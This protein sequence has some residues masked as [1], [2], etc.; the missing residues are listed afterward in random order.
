MNEIIQ[1]IS[2]KPS[3]STFQDSGFS[4]PSR[5]HSSDVLQF[6]Q[7]LQSSS[8]PSVSPIKSN[9]FSALNQLVGS[10]EE[11]YVAQ[12]DHLKASVSKVQDAQDIRNLLIAQYEGANAAVGLQLASKVGSKSA[13]AFEGLI[14]QQ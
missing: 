11:K 8:T 2:A 3:Q 10:A 6:N 13:E 5:P 7:L 1:S 9:E 14:R 4:Q 12:T